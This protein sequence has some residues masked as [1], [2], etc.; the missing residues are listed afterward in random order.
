M[1][2]TDAT[3]DA[4]SNWLPSPAAGALGITLR[5][6]APK[7]TVLNGQWVPPAVRKAK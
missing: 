1:I 3:A 2:A 4:E 6:Y 7:A 5:L